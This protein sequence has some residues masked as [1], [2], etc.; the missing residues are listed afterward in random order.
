[1]KY[2]MQIQIPNPQTGK[3]EWKSIKGSHMKEPYEYDTREEAERVLRICYGHALC[4]DEMRVI[5]KP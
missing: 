3:P 5:E 2:Q 4:R 1:M